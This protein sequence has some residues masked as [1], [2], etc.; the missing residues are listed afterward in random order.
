MAFFLE[1]CLIC[2]LLLGH[3][4]VLVSVTLNVL[5]LGGSG[6]G[7]K[8]ILFMLLIMSLKSITSQSITSKLVGYIMHYC[9]QSLN[10]LLIL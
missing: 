6:S 9:T 1:G 5:N 7:W 3:L 2:S 8:S 10:R 4:G